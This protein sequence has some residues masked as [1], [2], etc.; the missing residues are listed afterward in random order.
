MKTATMRF[1]WA[2]KGTYAPPILQQLWGELP[3]WIDGDHHLG[4]LLS[5]DEKHFRESEWRDVPYVLVE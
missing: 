5:A 2:I 3:E 4:D 1:R